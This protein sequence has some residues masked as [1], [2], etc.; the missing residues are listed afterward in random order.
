MIDKS[1]KRSI[2]KDV[3]RL[4]LVYNYITRTMDLN[5]LKLYGVIQDYFPLHNEWKLTGKDILMPASES[6]ESL[7]VNKIMTCILYSEEVE[8]EDENEAV[9]LKDKWSWS[10]VNQVIPLDSIK[11]YFGEKIGLKFAYQ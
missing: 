9:G 7:F 4:K 10:S 1:G 6:R 11:N 2:F 5:K 3:D 8:N